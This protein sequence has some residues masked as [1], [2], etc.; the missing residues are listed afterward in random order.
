MVDPKLVMLDE[1][2]AGVNPAWCSRL[3]DH[4]RRAA[5]RRAYRR[6]R[7]ARHGRRHG[8]QRL[9]RV[10]GRRARSSPRAPPA[11]DRR[12]TRVGHRRVPRHRATASDRRE[13]DDGHRQPARRRR[14]SSPATCPGVD[15]L[16]GCNLDVAD[17]RD[18]RHHR[19]E[20]RRQVDACS[21]RSSGWCRC[22]PARC[23]LRGDDITQLPRPRA[24][25]PRR[26]LRAAAS[27]TCSP[28]LTVDDNL[29]MG[30]YL[31]PARRSR[32]AARQRRRAASRGSA[33]GCTSAPGRSRA[34]SARCSRW[35]AR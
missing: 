25:R 9:G 15:I 10:H 13:R 20:R 3:L 30:A 24:R 18:R 22:A 26:R 31:R 28:S 19:A 35:R 27:A 1:P 12:P 16:H 2:M 11:D 29:R 8:H 21:R 33:S 17:R 5:G 14:T 23:M 32:D 7:R 4:I 6:V 34:V